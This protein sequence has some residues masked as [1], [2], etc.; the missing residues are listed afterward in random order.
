MPVF[1]GLFPPEHDQEIQ[2]LLFRL[3]QW[4]TLAKLRLHT[5][6][7]LKLLDEACR[8]L[9]G[10]L[11][12]FQDFTCA[13]FKTMELPSETAARWRQKERSLSTTA[14]G[15]SITKT[16]S[17][18]CQPKSFN[19]TTYKLHA[20]GDYV[21]NIRLFGTTD[22][23][24]T[25]LVSLIHT[26]RQCMTPRTRM[27]ELTKIIRESSLIAFSRGF[28]KIWTKNTQQDSWQHKNGGI[29]VSEDGKMWTP[30]KL[31]W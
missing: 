27:I 2:T 4:H 8:L 29:H 9:G 16:T 11:R 5:D 15:S 19:L 26:G 22:S 25:Q 17:A 30:S 24:T 28:I 3:A 6:H 7:S 18:A 13:A 1:E 10:Q 31:T 23:Y 21:R 14:P 20:L 12:K